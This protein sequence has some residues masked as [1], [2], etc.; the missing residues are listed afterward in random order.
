[1]FF[2]YF[3][4]EDGRKTGKESGSKMKMWSLTQMKNLLIF[5]K[6]TFI[7]LVLQYFTLKNDGQL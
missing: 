5:H 7:T 4:V 1:M 2:F 3:L 6:E